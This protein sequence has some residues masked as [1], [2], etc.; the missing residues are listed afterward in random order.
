MLQI[1]C[2]NFFLTHPVLETTDLSR[3]WLAA[4]CTAQSLVSQFRCI[5][6]YKG[7]G[8]TVPKARVIY[9]LKILCKNSLQA[10]I[11]FREAANAASCAQGRLT[12]VA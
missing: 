2:L 5:E 4:G 1:L 10:L 8:V 7:K 9:S 6:N 11:A 3:P 12:V